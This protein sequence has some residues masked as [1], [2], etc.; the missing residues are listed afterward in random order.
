MSFLYTEETMLILS[1]K[2]GERIMIGNGIE[3]VVQRIQGERV[4]LGIDAPSHIKILRGELALPPINSTETNPTPNPEPVAA[5]VCTS[6][7]HRAATGTME[8]AATY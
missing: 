5:N 1:R 4:T 7:C 8:L 2:L 3:V 6:D